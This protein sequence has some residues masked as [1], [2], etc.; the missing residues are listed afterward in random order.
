MHDDREW[1][2]PLTLVRHAD[3]VPRAERT[4][5]TASPKPER[6]TVLRER[7]QDGYYASASMMENVARR[8]LAVGDA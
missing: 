8:M 3:R 7:V 2:V 4:A 5:Q 6:V 1:I